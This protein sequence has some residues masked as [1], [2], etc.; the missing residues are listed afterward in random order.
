VNNN[1]GELLPPSSLAGNV[2]DDANNDGIFQS[3]ELGIGGVIVTLTGTDDLGNP[4]N[5]SI[6]TA[7]GG[8]YSFP[9][10]RPGT[11][12]ITETQPSGY[13]DGKDTIGTP[14]GT[15]AN[16]V[17]SN[18]VLGAGVN[19]VNNN[20][21]E[22]LP[23][24]LG[25]FVWYDTNLN[26]IQDLG[27]PGID[28]VTVNLYD[29]SGNLVD[30]TT[31]SGGG[32]YGFTNLTPG[33]YLVEFILPAG[34]VFSPQDQG[35]DDT[36]DSDADTTTGRTTLTTLTPGENDLTWDAGMYE[37]PASIGDFVWNDANANGIQES[38]EPGIDGV[39]VNLYDVSGNLVATTTTSGGGIYGFTGLTPGDY[40]VAFTLPAGFVFS[41]QN[42]GGND[43][44]DS[45]ADT[46]TGST[47]STTLIPGENDLTWDAGM[48]Q[49]EQ[50]PFAGCTPGYWKNHPDAWEP[51]GYTT[52]QM[53]SS[54]FTVPQGIDQQLANKS[55]IDTLDGGGGP[56]VDGAAQ[57]LLRAAVAALLNAAHP[58]IN[59]PLT[60]AQ[61]INDV[62][63]ALASLDRDTIL[64]L[65]TKLDNFNNL[66]CSCG[67]PPVG[68]N[69]AI[70]IQKTPDQQ[71]VN[72][73][74][75]VSF[76]IT[77]T[78]TGDVDLV[79]IV[80]TD[81][82]CQ[83]APTLQ[84][85]DTNSDNILQTTETWVYICA[86]NDVT[87]SFTNVATVSAQDGQG[88]TVNDSDDAVVTVNQP[89]EGLTPGYWKN[90]PES[91]PP[92]GYTTTQPV[93]TVFVVPTAI[94]PKI[95]SKSLKD[96]LGGG[97]GSD[98]NGAAKILLRAAV[99]ALLNAAHPNINYPRAK[100]QV[101]DDVNAALGSLNRDK[102]LAL[103][104]EL[105]KLNNLEGD[106][107]ATPVLNPKVQVQKPQVSVIDVPRETRVL[108]NF[109]NPFNPE[110][111]IPF[112]LAEAANV[113]IEIYDMTGRLVHTLDLGYRSAGYYVNQSAA[114]YWNGHNFSGERVASG[115]YFY[116]LISGERSAVRR[117]LILK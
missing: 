100:Q 85:G 42:Q 27:E 16:D 93:N 35:G 26:G 106:I 29:V 108:Q 76:T 61:I 80:V 57:I 18:I 8:S 55:L 111:W 25:D 56:D 101:I 50:E 43:A 116:R 66:G 84:S 59:Y 68:N 110:T 14:G 3:T 22:L 105:D 88:N 79:S 32:I 38:G 102:M 96:T 72:S 36:V 19:G 47:T 98:I 114:A 83:V 70:D 54:V 40:Y 4:V 11:Y 95:A 20:F 23:A 104:D 69:P 52:D 21:G 90:H 49:Q 31:T 78:N 13:L 51:T 7:F 15:T 17:F 112:E 1:F 87:Q 5:L 41:P 45:D 75:S 10:L 74:A 2:Y 115:L 33:N 103:A 6:M 28:G 77:V 92:T 60:V 86:V 53:V 113:K 67:E 81:P 99:A 63:A 89:A 34:F 46:T 117:M 65:A 109:P 44:V 64:A 9:N 97:G 107:S 73:G 39:T 48:Y 30:T 12:I 24:S 71:T 62:N 91:W 58:D 37:I 94:D 82:Q